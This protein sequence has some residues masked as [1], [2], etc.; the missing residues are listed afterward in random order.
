MK[1][2]YIE[3]VITDLVSLDL[4]ILIVNDSSTDHTENIISQFLDKENIELINNSKN[5][6]AGESTK[7]LLETVKNKNY[8]FLIKVD[9]SNRFSIQDVKKLKTSI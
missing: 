2:N 8:D 5:L 3:K 1:E 9:E 6:G 4:P 7:I